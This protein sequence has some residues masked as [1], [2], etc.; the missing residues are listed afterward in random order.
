MDIFILVEKVLDF[1]KIPDEYLSPTKNVMKD[2]EY[3]SK[4]IPD[5]AR[6]RKIAM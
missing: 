3:A 4:F 1:S 5:Y 2:K 6:L